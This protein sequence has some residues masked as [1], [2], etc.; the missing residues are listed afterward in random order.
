MN[1]NEIELVTAN[2]T[3]SVSV[4]LDYTPVKVM[5]V[6]TNKLMSVVLSAAIHRPGD[7]HADARIHTGVLYEENNDVSHPCVALVNAA[8][9]SYAAYYDSLSWRERAT[10]TRRE[11]CVT[12]HRFLL[13]QVARHTDAVADCLTMA[14]LTAAKKE[15]DIQQ[16]KEDLLM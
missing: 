10:M 6:G 11:H 4:A 14:A 2:K 12:L 13:K 5:E 1:P 3:I 8:L 16:E 9:A 15:Q 7:S